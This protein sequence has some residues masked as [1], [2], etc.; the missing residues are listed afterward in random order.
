MNSTAHWRSVALTWAVVLVGGAFVFPLAWVLGA[1]A[2]AVLTLVLL[3]RIP[4]A[5]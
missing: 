2:V 4:P 5:D 1:A 3:A